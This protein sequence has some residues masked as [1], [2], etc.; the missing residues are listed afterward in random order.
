M[1]RKSSPIPLWMSTIIGLAIAIILLPMSHLTVMANPPNSMN[2]A[3]GLVTTA[4]PMVA[5]MWHGRTL[6]NKAE[7]YT[8]YLNEAGLAKIRKIPG[9][10]GV[11]ML[12]R[13]TGRETEFYVI[14]YWSSREA[15]QQF[16]GKDI[17]KVRSLPRDP[18]FLIE[19]EP[20]VKH[21]DLLVD[22]WKRST[23]S[24]ENDQ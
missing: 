24:V 10:K 13:S 2:I 6:A 9:N 17:N 12:R 8:A 7:A 23:L 15:I 21:F 1:T 20:T 18:K 19:V 16:A 3:Q 11:Q 22:D 4:P 5:R 14:S